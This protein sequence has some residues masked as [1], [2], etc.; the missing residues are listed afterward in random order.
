MSE[1]GDGVLPRH[2]V[3]TSSGPV[4]P[5]P[6]APAE[7]HD[8]SPAALNTLQ[9]IGHNEPHN[10]LP[11]P[12]GHEPKAPE[13]DIQ[14]PTV[15]N[16]TSSAQPL[17]RFSKSAAQ[18]H[19]LVILARIWLLIAGLYRRA[20]MFDDSREACDEA[21]KAA[22]R[23][24]S[25]AAAQESSARAFGT[26]GWGGGKSSDEVWADVLCERAALA[27]ARSESKEAVEQYE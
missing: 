4:P 27:S 24:E 1:F 18:K 8:S 3:D 26:P 21:D 9:P 16:Q 15:N 12:Q 19:G 22:M 25:L 2:S 11:P 20:M 6:A 14:L 17:P 7:L 10:E 5:T 13:Q 23:I